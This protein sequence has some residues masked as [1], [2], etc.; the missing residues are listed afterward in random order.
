MILSIKLNQFANAFMTKLELHN[1]Q[2]SADT[3]D[4]ALCEIEC[5]Q[6]GSG[7]AWRVVAWQQQCDQKLFIL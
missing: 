1:R 6:S 2:R 5:Q 7:V 3:A 4:T